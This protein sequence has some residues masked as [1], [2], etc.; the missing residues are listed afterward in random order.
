MMV[1]R[2]VYKDIVYKQQYSTT[3]Q[4]YEATDEPVLVQKDHYINFAQIPYWTITP[5]EETLTLNGKEHVLKGFLLKLGLSEPVS[6][7][8]APAS[9]TR[10]V[11]AFRE[12]RSYN[13]I[14]EVLSPMAHYYQTMLKE[15]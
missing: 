12:A 10:I 5:Q 1:V 4:R 2:F 8:I 11:Q 9:A 13:D 3:A 7:W 14:G 6:L 15:V